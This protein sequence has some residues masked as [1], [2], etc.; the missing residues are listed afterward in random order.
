[1]YSLAVAAFEEA[2]TES[3]ASAISFAERFLV[4]LKSR[5]SKKCVEPNCPSSSSLEPTETLMAID[6]LGAAGTVS[7]S[8]LI[9]LG[10]RVLLIVVPSAE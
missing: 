6:T 2:P 10:K 7:V 5:C 3:N 8:T 9:P 4:P 1:V